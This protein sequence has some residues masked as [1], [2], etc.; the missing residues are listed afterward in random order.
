MKSPTKYWKIVERLFL[1][2]DFYMFQSHETK[3]ITDKFEH[4]NPY[5]DSE[6]YPKEQLWL[7][8]LDKTYPQAEL[9]NL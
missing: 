8:K 7:E 2:K 3:F 5:D 6:L 4:L 9:D 1:N